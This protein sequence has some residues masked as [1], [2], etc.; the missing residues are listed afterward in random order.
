MCKHTYN[1]HIHTHSHAY[2]QPYLLMGLP[3][4]L[5]RSVM[6]CRW[7]E[8]YSPTLYPELLKMELIIVAVEPLP[9]VSEQ[10]CKRSFLRQQSLEPRQWQ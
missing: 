10:V 2:M 6:L 4:T 3:C 7:G 9:A 5:M 8:V 1:K